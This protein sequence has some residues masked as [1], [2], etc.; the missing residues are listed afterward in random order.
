MITYYEIKTKSIL[1]NLES[2]NLQ[3]PA[4]FNKTNIYTLQALEII[5]IN[6]HTWLQYFL[7][8]YRN[9]MP[10]TDYSYLIV[11]CQDHKLITLRNQLMDFDTNIINKAEEYYNKLPWI[12]RINTKLFHKELSLEIQRL[13][14]IYQTRYTL[15]YTRYLCKLNNISIISSHGVSMGEMDLLNMLKKY[16]SSIVYV[17]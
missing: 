11:Y 7:E 12:K 13:E 5:Y 4:Y 17:I 10:G 9:K 3:L 1:G 8:L 15:P 2:N 14:K 6:D 16:H